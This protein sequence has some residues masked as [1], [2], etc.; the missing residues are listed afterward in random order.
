MI[1][2]TARLPRRR[3]ASA[4]AAVAA[5]G[6]LVSGCA[7]LGGS[8]REKSSQE[9][10][11]EGTRLA[12]RKRYEEAV[13][14][15]REASRTYRGADLDADIQIAL[16]D[17]QFSNEEYTAAGEAYAEF[18]RMHPHNARA[19]YAQLR[20]GLSWS[21]QMGSAERSQEAARKA[22]AAYEALLRGYPRSSLLEEGRRGLKEAR[23]RIAEHEFSVGE[24]Y[25][26]RGSDRAAAG[27]FE[28]V[29]R[30]FADLGF[31][32][33]ALYE[34][35]RCYERL[36][37]TERAARLFEQLRREYPQSRYLKELDERKS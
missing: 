14:A 26:R 24:F 19:D 32:E 10:Y 13:Q 8:A 1:H 21:K 23:R 29:L 15:F 20:V 12:S 5:T 18:L 11:D 9:L 31:A 16:A 30:D 2:N 37:E 25:S 34:L 27:R 3:L 6:L 22:V 33:R 36:Q 17:A 35:G 7:G 28:V 4:L